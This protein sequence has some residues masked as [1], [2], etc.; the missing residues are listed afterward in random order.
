MQLSAA[1]QEM[2]TRIGNGFAAALERPTFSATRETTPFS[3]LLQQQTGVVALPAGGMPTPARQSIAEVMSAAGIPIFKTAGGKDSDA[4]EDETRISERQSA[5]EAARDPDFG[6]LDLAGSA[7]TTNA[8][9]MMPVQETTSNSLPA[10]QQVREA[11]EDA[12]AHATRAAIGAPSARPATAAKPY[13]EWMA[14][15]APKSVLHA[16][17][18]KADSPASGGGIAHS[19]AEA[20][21][22]VGSQAAVPP[23]PWSAAVQ[24]TADASAMMATGAPHPIETRSSTVP[25]LPAQRQ[26]A[27]KVQ[28]SPFRVPDSSGKPQAPTAMHAANASE[29]LEQGAIETRGSQTVSEV[30]SQPVASPHAAKTARVADMAAAAAGGTHAADLRTAHSITSGPVSVQP[31]SSNSVAISATVLAPRAATPTLV[32]H[33]ASSV[34]ASPF[35]RMDSA[36]VPQV[37]ESAPQRLSVGVRDSGLGWVEVRAHAAGGHISAVLGAAGGEA[38]ATLAAHLP[39][40]REFL[41]TQQ[42]RV[43]RLSSETL[44]PG[45]GNRQGKSD[46][47][48]AQSQPGSGEEPTQESEETLFTA[49]AGEQPLSYINVRA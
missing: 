27:Q 13:P 18:G 41:A 1:H 42:V 43:D 20:K 9:E 22:S 6:R 21:N 14:Q 11:P 47:E 2:A 48:Q 33:A 35:A 24:P 25:D 19:V 37:L 32:A 36:N 46:G 34:S 26:A 28:S 29:K 8:P 44:P 39:E 17:A 4:S 40:V 10:A 38:R 49:P 15:G 12:G 7:S 31:S 5:P 23:V 3:E 45:A 16:A 30:E